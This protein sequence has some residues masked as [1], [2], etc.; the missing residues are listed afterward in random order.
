MA[1]KILIKICSSFM[2]KMLIKFNE[3]F[4]FYF[5]IKGYFS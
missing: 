4:E 3:I 1:R 2:L 5:A